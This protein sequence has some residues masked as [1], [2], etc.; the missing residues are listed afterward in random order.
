MYFNEVKHTIPANI[1]NISETHN[2]VKV[3]HSKIH[4]SGKKC[5][6][7]KVQHVQILDACN[8][9]KNATQYNIT[10]MKYV[11]ICFQGELIKSFSK[12]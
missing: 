10:K 8:E 3:Q 5:N 11:K 2:F 9:I 7:Q 1:L 12:I 4:Y 6:L